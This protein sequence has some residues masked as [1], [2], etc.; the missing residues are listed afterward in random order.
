MKRILIVGMLMISTLWAA[1]MERTAAKQSIQPNSVETSIQTR[2]L[3]SETGSTVVFRELRDSVGIYF[4]DFEGDVSGWV[5]GGQWTLTEDNS[6]SPTHSFV[7]DDDPAG[8]SNSELLSPMITLPEVSEVENLTF[9]FALFCDFPD[10]DGDGDNSLEDY[11]FVKVADMTSIPWHPSDYNAFESDI[12]WWC[13][14]EDIGGYN[15][16]WLQF[17]DTDPIILPA[18]ASLNFKVKYALEAYSGASQTI[19]GCEIDG[20]DVANV[21][22]S[23][24]AGENWTTLAGSPAYQSTSGFGWSFNGDG[25]DI[26]GWGGISA[27]WVNASYD[28]AAYA[29]QQ[30]MIRFAFGS[31]ASYSTVDDATL[32]GFYVDNILVSTAADTLFYN[33]ATSEDN[34]TASGILWADLFY[35]YSDP[36]S[37][38]PGSSSWEIY[39]EGMQFNGSLDLTDMAGKDIRIM[40]RT[41]I[42]DNNDGGDGTGFHIDDVSVYKTSQLILPVPADVTAEAMAGEVALSWTDVNESQEVTFA[43]GDETLESFIAGS[44]PWMSGQVVGS[45]WTSRYET[46]LPTTLQTFSYVLSSG[47]TTDPGSILPIIVTVW[48]DNEEIIFESEPVTATAMDELMTYDLSPANISVIGSFYVG[49]AYTDTT[50]PFVALDSDSP[51]E[52]EAYGW[53]PEG[54]MLSLTGTGMD[55]N[56]AL[57]ATGVTSSAGGFT[58]NVYRREA[59]AGFT[60]PLNDTPLAA[61]FYTDNTVTNGVGYYYA[62]TTVF[63]GDEGDFSDE[64]YVL[65]ESASVYTMANDDGSS[66][67]GFNLGA[68]GYQAVKFTPDGY[69][70]LIKRLKLY[71]HGNPTGTASAIAYVW[72]DDGD[73]GMPLGE[74]KRTG[75]SGLVHGWNV[76]DISADSIWITSGSFYVGAKEVNSTPSLGADT[77]NYSGLSFYNAGEGWDNMSNL[78]LSYNLMFRADVDSAF[79]VVGIDDVPN[80]GIPSQ[81]AL[82]QNYPNPFNPATIIDYALPEAGNVELKIFDLTGRQVDVIVQEHQAPGYYT[83]ELDASHMNSGIY[84]YSLNT[85]KTHITRKMILLK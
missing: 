57:Y 42:D 55:G 81:Y 34:M 45:A 74:F 19:D 30:V 75:W 12:S 56:Y 60:T 69:P 33:D 51:Y 72:D 54:T 28:L 50:A 68:G 16:A 84:I 24:D 73:D 79:V 11:Y 64:V 23:T 71:V 63:E 26:P 18:G 82:S 22:I 40:W 31:D 37:P 77:D 17:L 1:N 8:A 78:G 15:D 38:R 4:D 44:V 67:F 59:D 46:G 14:S 6:Y 39:Q 25:C 13:G 43:H 52:G 3:D 76:K 41:R 53:H 20:W 7:A 21:R 32:T 65:P 35:D 2:V 70:T 48:D 66:E 83:V 58:Y 61:A 10:A 85:G 9:D 29:E 36:A 80:A 62:I 5:A 27:G 49:W 47:N